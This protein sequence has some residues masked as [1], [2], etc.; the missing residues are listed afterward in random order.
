MPKEKNKK[1]IPPNKEYL[2]YKKKQN[3]CTF[4]ISVDFTMVLGLKIP[5]KDIKAKN[6]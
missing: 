2:S 4:Y 6:M 5:K 3:V 1:Q